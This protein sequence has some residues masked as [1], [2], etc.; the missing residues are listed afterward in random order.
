VEVFT[1]LV[2]LRKSSHALLAT[3]AVL[4]A[5]GLAAC[6]RNQSAMEALTG[7]SRN[8]SGSFQ[9][10]AAQVASI[11]VT[12]STVAGGGTSAGRVTLDRTSATPSVVALT[13]NNAAAAVPASVTVAAGATS[14][15]FTATTTVVTANRAVTL[16]ASFAGT[17]RSVTLTVTAAG[18][19][20]PPPPPPPAAAALS[21]LTLTPTTVDAGTSSTGRVTLTAAAPVGGSIVSL[22]SNNAAASV[23]ASVTVAAGATSATFTATT[24]PAI[25]VSALATVTATLGTVSRTASLTVNPV[26][27]CVSLAGKSSTV[28]AT[29]AAV[30]QFRATRLRVEITGD[31]PAGYI[32]TLGGCVPVAAPTVNF[33]SGTGSLTRGGA[34]VTAT[35]ATLAFGPLLFPGLALEPGVV[36]ATDAVGNVLEIVW[37]GLAGLAPGAPILRLQLAARDASIRAGDVLA[38]TMTFTATAANG[39]T[40]TFTANGA[41]MV[42][43]PLR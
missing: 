26:S 12:P 37:P 21:T 18:G 15:T 2:S 27:P 28:V 32:N 36:I 11:S 42:V 19:V 16:T 23:P 41:N 39:T 4:S 10:G 7:P 38:T 43:P 34:A 33:T 1:M 14:A 20:V 9:G 40:A 31:V 8:G 13:S 17:S 25:T 29:T 35:H 6:S 5:I 3:L 24:N 30:V 22:S